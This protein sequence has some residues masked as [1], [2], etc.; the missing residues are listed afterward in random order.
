MSAFNTTL[1][2]SN[3]MVPVPTH[4]HLFTSGRQPEN[5]EPD[6]DIPLLIL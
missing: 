4:V 3:H 1:A 5:E 6:E 2:P